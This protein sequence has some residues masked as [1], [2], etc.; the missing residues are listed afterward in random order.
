MGALASN[1]FRQVSLGAL[2][3]PNEV[4][5]PPQLVSHAFRRT[6]TP[7]PLPEPYALRRIATRQPGLSSC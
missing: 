2:G 7:N 1:F 5:S 6:D 4:A 3:A